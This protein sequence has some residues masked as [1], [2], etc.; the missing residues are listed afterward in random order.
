MENLLVT[1]EQ[2]EHNSTQIPKNFLLWRCR[3][4][5]NVSSTHGVEIPH[6][7][8]S[9]PGRGAKTLILRVLPFAQFG[10]GGWGVRAIELTLFTLAGLPHFGG[11]TS[12]WR[13]HRLW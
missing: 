10:R 12:L 13:V 2:G 1:I 4:L 7:N 11:F 6:P 5:F 8:P 9:P 3:G